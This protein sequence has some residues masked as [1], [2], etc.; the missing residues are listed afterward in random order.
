VIFYE[1]TLYQKTDEGVE[2]VTLLKEKGIIPGIKVSLIWNALPTVSI[3]LS[4]AI[5]IRSTRELNPWPAPTA[6]P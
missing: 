2:F 6:R 3:M 4:F 1:E 5:Y